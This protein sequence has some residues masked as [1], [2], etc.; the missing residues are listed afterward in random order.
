MKKEESL[1]DIFLY[2][3]THLL[4]EMETKLLEAES[5]KRT[6]KEWIDNVFRIMHTI[7]GS[8]AMLN[9]KKLS[10]LSHGLEDVYS[11]I[12]DNNI[13]LTEETTLS[14]SSSHGNRGT[15]YRTGRYFGTYLVLIIPY[16]VETNNNCVRLP[17]LHIEHL[18][19]KKRYER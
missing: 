4:D 8:S 11:F 5:N 3:T 14:S 18:L 13:E 19:M 1:F 16:V 2:E 7:K 10:E 12:R 15:W 17:T 9:F 6:N